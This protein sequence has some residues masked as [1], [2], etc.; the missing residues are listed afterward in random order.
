[1][2]QEFIRRGL[3][4]ELMVRSLLGYFRCMNNGAEAS[5]D[6]LRQGKSNITLLYDKR[7]DFKED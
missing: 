2:R 3:E 6:S 1:M 5:F 7:N 4:M